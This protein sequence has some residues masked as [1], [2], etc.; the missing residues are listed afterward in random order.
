[1]IILNLNCAEVC[2][3]V[4]L[5]RSKMSCSIWTVVN[6]ITRQILIY[7]HL[8]CMILISLWSLFVRWF[9]FVPLFLVFESTLASNGLK[10]INL[11]YFFLSIYWWKIASI[12]YSTIRFS[13]LSPARYTYVHQLRTNSSRWWVSEI[14]LICTRKRIHNSMQ[15]C[16]YNKKMNAEMNNFGFNLGYFDQL[17]HLNDWEEEKEGDVHRM[18]LYELNRHWVIPNR[19]KKTVILIHLAYKYQLRA[20]STIIRS[21]RENDDEHDREQTVPDELISQIHWI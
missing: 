11:L 20:A 13:M 8:S 12:F 7:L 3:C 14:K 10:L 6:A 2:V 19:Q 16:W 15:K 9:F 18:N 5:A 4:C 17:S 21:I 1:M